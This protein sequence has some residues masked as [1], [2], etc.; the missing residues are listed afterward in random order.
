MWSN[1]TPV[2]AQNVMFW[3]NMELDIPADYGLY[4][5]FPANVGDMKAVS[6]TELTMTMNKSYS[7]PVKPR[8]SEFKEVPFITAASEYDVLQ[9]P[10]SSTKV[11]V[12]YVPQEDVPPKPANAAVGGN[13]L[14]SKGYTPAGRHPADADD[15]HPAGELVFR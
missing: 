9:S 11:N 7:G 14:A 13:P 4:S 5:G 10:N 1:G 2:T 8:L 3:L 15:R 12:G 6:S